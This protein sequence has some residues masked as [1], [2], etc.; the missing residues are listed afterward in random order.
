M[1]VI[2]AGEELG[3]LYADKDYVAGFDDSTIKAFRLRVQQILAAPDEGT[4][5]AL[6]SLDY[7]QVRVNDSPKW[8]MRLNGRGRLILEKQAEGKATVIVVADI[9][10]V[11]VDT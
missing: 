7:R 8:S 11:S 4:F 2:F 9:V 10:D 3:R 1:D 5:T 6:K